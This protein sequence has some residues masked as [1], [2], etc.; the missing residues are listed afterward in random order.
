MIS[1]LI[2]IAIVLVILGLAVYLLGFLPLPSPFPQ[3]IKVVAIVMAVIY[4][5]NAFI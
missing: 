2:S 5:V 3:L 1:T 4:I